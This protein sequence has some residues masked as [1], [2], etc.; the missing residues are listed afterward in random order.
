MTTVESLWR[1]S[2]RLE[3]SCALPHEFFTS[4]LIDH[5]LAS[6][7][8][9]PMM[10]RSKKRKFMS[11]L[12]DD[13]DDLCLVPASCD[14]KLIEWYFGD[15]RKETRLIAEFKGFATRDE[16]FEWLANQNVLENVWEAT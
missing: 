5:V 16:V 6:F 11:E 3:L 14:W 12:T 7:C 4:G 9:W 15:G 2:L 8:R 13:H 10:C 1:R